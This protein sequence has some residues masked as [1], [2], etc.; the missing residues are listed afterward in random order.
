MRRAFNDLFAFTIVA[1]HRSFTRAAAHLGTS[2]SSLSQTIRNLE[3]NL[4]VRLLTRSTRSVA[5]TEAGERLLERLKPQFE[6]IES[7]LQ[8]LGTTDD[9]PRGTIRISAGEHAALS[10]LRPKIASFLRDYPDISIEIAVDGGLIDIVAD[11]FDAGVRLGEQVAKDMIAVRIGPKICMAMVMAP[12]YAQTHG[13]PETPEA[14]T[15][16]RCINTRMPTHGSIFMWELQK[17]GHEF[18]VRV[19]G[20]V[21]FN[22]LPMRLSA[23]LDG[24]GIGYLPLDQVETHLAEG[25]LLPVL[26]DHWPAWEGY[27]LY[28][29]N[30]R[31]M[32]PAFRLLI[33][34]LR[35]RAGG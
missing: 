26:Q 25:R 2:Q 20:P 30:R 19:D 1:H 28:Y 6:D 24:I 31:Q 16:H 35:H 32:R 27:H 4:G 21:T 14:L 10:V 15:A 18:R 9:S 3:A 13:C 29:P 17:D 33:D 7:A 12:D 34:A 5:P 22:S 23:A 8:E 11:G